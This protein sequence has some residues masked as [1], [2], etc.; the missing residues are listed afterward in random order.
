MRLKDILKNETIS[1]E[2]VLSKK[3]GFE[4]TK[5][6]YNNTLTKQMTEYQ[7]KIDQMETIFSTKE[8]DLYSKYAKLE[9]IMSNYNN[10]MTYLSQSLGLSS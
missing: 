10:Q 9:T 8:Q 2:S 4:G 5:T 7:K 1:S 3:V 6:V